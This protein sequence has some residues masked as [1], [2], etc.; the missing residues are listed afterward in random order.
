MLKH[1][2]AILLTAV[3]V[4]FC[5]CLNV[6][7]WIIGELTLAGQS[8]E[9]SRRWVPPT[10]IAIVT[11]AP[12]FLSMLI[13]S[14]SNRRERSRSTNQIFALTTD[15][16]SREYDIVQKDN[17][18]KARRAEIDSLASEIKSLKDAV[19]IRDLQLGAK[20]DQ[21]G[22]LTSLVFRY[23][24]L[25]VTVDRRLNIL[26]LNR[27]D[28]TIPSTRTLLRILQKL[29]RKHKINQLVDSVFDGI[30]D[31]QI[32]ILGAE[33][34]ATDKS[35]HQL[36]VY[37]D[38]VIAHR[39][40]VVITDVTEAVHGVQL[41]VERERARLERGAGYI[42]TGGFTVN[43]DMKVVAGWGKFKKQR[44]GTL[45]APR[46]IDDLL[47]DPGREI[48]E[49][50]RSCFQSNA[51]QTI[52][53]IAI[54][55]KGGSQPRWLRLDIWP[56]GPGLV[57]G[58]VRDITKV[59]QLSEKVRSLAKLAT[60]A[61]EAYERGKHDERAENERIVHHFKNRITLIR[62][63][64]PSDIKATEQLRELR[65]VER[66]LGE[67]TK[68]LRMSLS[69]TK[70]EPMSL[71]KILA[72]AAATAGT[73]RVNRP[74]PGQY[75][76]IS[77]SDSSGDRSYALQLAVSE[78]LHNAGK[79]APSR[80]GQLVIVEVRIKILKEGFEI[81][82]EDNGAHFDPLAMEQSE[83]LK[84]TRLSL[85]GHDMSLR[86]ERSAAGGCRGIITVLNL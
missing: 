23:P 53:A 31:E 67:E 19:A 18:L 26:D 27:V 38:P 39:V 79:Y 77:W 50:C 84:F 69:L 24:Q 25:M 73:I 7:G 64:M 49:A 68:R 47:S 74:E 66:D 11:A 29:L 48:E 33:R 42:G 20:E 40:M 57:S 3:G 28:Q 6:S 54:Q 72:S 51:R 22:Q 15:V 61:S 83:G 30:A 13:S 59:V 52:E 62:Q 17:L 45:P 70:R 81:V 1:T 37:R 76:R 14:V 36:C 8:E 86:F 56:D 65:S 71:M 10:L 2:L 41:Q 5:L 44:A 34:E 58:V 82:I 9:V 63:Q 4:I 85:E 55:D 80:G 12:F 21:L 43:K 32:A 60:L 35:V 75:D 78:L 16:G 46:F